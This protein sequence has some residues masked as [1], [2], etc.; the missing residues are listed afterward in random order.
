MTAATTKEDTAL[1]AAKAVAEA[2]AGARAMTGSKA[3]VVDVA[4][5]A[6]DQT[7]GKGAKARCHAGKQMA[8]TTTASSTTS[9]CPAP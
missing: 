4:A 6:K 5:M 2:V 1:G 3:A 8:V 7:P 9:R